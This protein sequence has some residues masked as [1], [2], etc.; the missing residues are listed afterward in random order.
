MTIYEERRGSV[1]IL[2]LNGSFVGKS[3]ASLFERAVFGL[4]KDDCTSIILNLA[5][6]KFIDSAGL[7]AIITAMVSVGRRDGAL[8]LAAVRGEVQNTVTGMHL[9][10]V[11]E[12]H[13]SVEQAVASYI[14]KGRT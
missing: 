9:D 12:L 5:E 1:G 6:L 8:K 11:F 3:G 7:G 4:L 2:S 13:D 14:K 10:Q